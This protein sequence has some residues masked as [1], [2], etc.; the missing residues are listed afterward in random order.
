MNA[1]VML[2]QTE[3]QGLGSP[4]YHASSE[5]FGISWTYLESPY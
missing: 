3:F 1:I 2:R 4:H 5:A